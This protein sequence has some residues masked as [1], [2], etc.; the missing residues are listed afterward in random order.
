MTNPLSKIIRYT[1]T[2]RFE[3]T[4]EVSERLSRAA[5][6]PVIKA[7]A[8]KLSDRTLVGSVSKD[9]VRL[10]E[11][12]PF[13]GNIFKPIFNGRFESGDGRISLI[14]RFEIGTVGRVVIGVFLSFCLVI[15]VILLPLIGTES[16]AG[17]IGI[18]EPTL[19]L[20]GGALLVLAA[21]A[22]SKGQIPWITQKIEAAL[23][24]RVDR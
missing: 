15:Q 5:R 2:I 1:D 9:Y 24:Q 6:T 22:Y 7:A 12:A 21:K 4:G 11:V 17:V 10:H 3:A 20:L 23:E 14:G 19:F 13:F 16:G 18:F 8:G